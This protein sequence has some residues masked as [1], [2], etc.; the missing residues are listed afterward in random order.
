M[1]G[2][3]GSARAPPLVSAYSSESS[4]SSPASIA[5]HNA[6]NSPASV[7]GMLVKDDVDS[8]N[9]ILFGI[10]QSY[11]AAAVA[12]QPP[13][14]RQPIP[15]TSSAGYGLYPA[16]PTADPNQ[17]D[18]WER[19]QAPQHAPAPAPA[20]SHH[21]QRSY[22][23]PQSMSTATFYPSHHGTLP[24]I[25]HSQSA[26]GVSFDYMASHR[27]PAPPAIAPDYGRD[28]TY[29]RIDL[30]TRAAAPVSNV[31]GG[32]EVTTM[33]VDEKEADERVGK[34]A[35]VEEDTVV[36]DDEV[37]GVEA[38][39]EASSDESVTLAP[40]TGGPDTPPASI[41]L[42]PLREALAR[43]VL[44]AERSTVPQEPRRGLYPSLSEVDSRT[45]EEE[46]VEEDEDMSEEERS[47]A[48]TK[49]PPAK[50]A[51]DGESLSPGR[52]RRRLMVI[53]MLLVRVNEA[54]RCGLARARVEG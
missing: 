1:F 37:D 15:S 38:E 52:A 18:R 36:K 53:K 27:P 28:V 12:P 26:N 47:E 5:G 17:W 51:S 11:E 42:R 40:I 50:R 6:G 16:L 49:T 54:Y 29:R 45:D 8:L 30:L 34:E 22:G 44:T 2:S 13:S 31:R 10:G 23:S 46:D 9:E 14:P 32:E 3:P 24:A 20:H 19:P 41:A 7:D 25:P 39:G 4:A 35:A 48:G 33:D 21:R 43:P